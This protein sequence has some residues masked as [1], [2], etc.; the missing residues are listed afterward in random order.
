MK[1]ETFASLV[2]AVL[3]EKRYVRLFRVYIF[4]NFDLTVIGTISS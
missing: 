2:S 4:F 1:P 3:Y